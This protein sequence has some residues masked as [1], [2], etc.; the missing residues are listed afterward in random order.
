[1]DFFEFENLVE[2]GLNEIWKEMFFTSLRNL[3]KN[4]CERGGILSLLKFTIWRELNKIKLNSMYRIWN[5]LTFIE[6]FSE[7]L[8]FIFTDFLRVDDFET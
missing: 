8:L 4:C 7:S 3:I 1:M 6:I 2:L 5:F